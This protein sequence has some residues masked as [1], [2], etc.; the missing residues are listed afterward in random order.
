MS[1]V[2]SSP[3]ESS[4]SGA[5]SQHH[6]GAGDNVLGDKVILQAISPA[7]IQ[8]T[9]R[10]IL[11]SLRHRQPT[12]AKE[13]LE[14]LKTTTNLNA[15][16]EGILDILSILIQVAN[17]NPPSDAYLLLGNYLKTTSDGLCIDITISAQIRLDVKNEHIID[18]RKRYIST[19]NP[20]VYT[21][22]VF[23]EFIADK[24]EIE[25]TYQS[26]RLDLVEVELCGLIR[27][28][29]RLKIP[30]RAF[31]IAEYLNSVAPTFNSRSFL[32]LSKASIVESKLEHKHYW[33]I[34]ATLRSDILSLCDDVITLLND[35]DGKDARIISLSASLLHFVFGEYKP[36]A[37][38]CW[39]YVSEIEC[40]FPEIA[41]QIRHMYDRRLDNLDGILYKIAKASEDPFYKKKIINEITNSKEISIE[42]SALLGDIGDTKSLQKWIDDGG[43]V[44]GEDQFVKDFSI[45]EL[46][47]LA[48]D[49]D[50]K[51]VDDIGRLAEIFILEH[52]LRI[53]D[54]N[55]YRLLHLADKLMDLELSYVACELLKPHVPTRDA[56]VSPTFYCY[57]KALLNSQQMMTLHTI[58]SEINP[59]DWSA[60]IW[61]IKAHQLS[62]LHDYIGAIEAMETAI[63]KA[64]LLP[65]SWYLLV[66]FHKKHEGDSNI[67]VTTLDRI[68]EEVFSRP[69]QFGF[70]LLAD[71]AI[72][73][74]FTRAEK[75]LISWFIENPDACSIPFTNVYLSIIISENKT[76][77][78]LNSTSNCFG[79]VCYS[80]DGKITTKLLVSDDVAPHR[81]L[82]SI[83][84]P[85]GKLLSEMSVGDSVQY[86]MRDIK[87]IEC[88]PPFIAAFQIASTLRQAINDGRDCFHSFEL[89]KDPDE[90]LKS[91]ERK[92]SSSNKGGEGLIAEPK[93]P[94][95]M[96]G[97]HQNALSPVKSALYH[98]TEKKSVKH[99][100]PGFGEENFEHMILD[101]YSVIY[102][103]LTGLAH[104]VFEFPSRLIITNETKNYL[105]DWLKD[106]NRADYLTVG[107][108]PEGGL[109]RHTA[110]DIQKQTAEV[111]DAMR[112]IIGKSEVIAPSLVDIPDQVLR[113]KNIVDLSVFSS[114]KLSITNNIP[115]LCIDE[116]FAHLSKEI[117]YRTVNA[118]QFFSLIGRGLS[119][120]QKKQG[121]YLHVSAAFPY[122]LTF[123][124]M[125]QLSRSKDNYAHYLLAELMEMYPNA[126]SDTG[127]AIQFLI[128]VLSSIL[129]NASSNREILNGLKEKNPRN[130]GHIEHIFNV[131][132]FTSMQ[133]NDGQEA[134][135]KLAY[136][137]GSLLYIFRDIHT[138]NKLIQIM[139]SGFIAGHFM[140][141]SAINNHI[142][143][144][145]RRIENTDP[146]NSNGL[147]LS[148]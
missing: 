74:N 54:L 124:D 26:K 85:L 105:E 122:A 129:I 2:S 47:A 83:S 68:P 102:L 14:T 99:P 31:V 118:N 96:K 34:S 44:S 15:D 136:L 20:G 33:C 51:S 109:Y 82:L 114:L 130:N 87:L 57:L 106:I 127:S 76:L 147:D 145:I 92:L 23:Y 80:A 70:S 32:A 116:T 13:Q 111:Q 79:G 35:C 45:L 139:A 101:V 25:E 73:G 38:A 137:L 107:V 90:M 9:I 134:E 42:D 60:E 78:F 56:W 30:E 131:C 123:E 39:S 81:D 46:K 19:D 16:T 138:M 93:I 43:T 128:P 66:D 84:S 65:N 100:L 144:V 95:F 24:S 59:I 63:E 132:C 146:T 117:G 121:L 18:A 40:Q 148:H 67:I 119:L 88:S 64:P 41:A 71:M 52:I 21:K 133:C 104:G 3:D 126:F 7:E 86:G 29:L 1:N 48:C 112:S 69:S 103:S 17:D 37:D 97:H 36:L 49:D 12:Q 62:N 28:A 94:L 11:T 50:P 135:K 91:L 143:D 142:E 55:P 115:W 4:K 22:E 108:Y 110:E 89:P 5:P 141:F 140:S 61:Q 8:H 120:E 75:F 6:S 27:G 53:K 72:N 58:M 77:N 125:F 10:R 113:I 98:L